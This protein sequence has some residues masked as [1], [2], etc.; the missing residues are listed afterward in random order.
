M[1]SK[2]ELA[3]KLTLLAEAEVNFMQPQFI[4]AV[5]SRN[6]QALEFQG[7]GLSPGNQDLKIGSGLNSGTGQ[8][9]SPGQQTI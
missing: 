5:I 6:F 7:T 4:R 1:R 2:T 8:P 9:G 3:L